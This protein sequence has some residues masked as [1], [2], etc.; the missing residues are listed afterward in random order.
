M[1]KL[2]VAILMLGLMCSPALACQGGNCSDQYIGAFGTVDVSSSASGSGMDMDSTWGAWGVSAAGGHA[3]AGGS[4]VVYDGS[5]GVDVSTIAGGLTDTTAYSGG[6]W[7]PNGW[8]YY[9][10]VG[11][12][13]QAVVGGSV[14]VYV[15]GLGIVGAGFGG[16]AC[17][18]SLDVSSLGS[19]SGIAGQASHA[20]I[21]GLA[22]ALVWGS[23][24]AGGQIDMVGSSGSTSWN[25][26]TF[27][28]PAITYSIGTNV[29]AQTQIN[30]V[31]YD[32]SYGIAWSQVC[33]SYDVIGSA[34]T[35]TTVPGG[36]ASASG[37]YAGHG[38]L[39]TNY[40]G[41][42]SGY[43]YGSITT[44]SGMHGEIVSTGAGMHVTS[45]I[46]L[47]R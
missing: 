20:E 28:G 1:K 26:I 40:T 25:E 8:G 43:S 24:Y 17:Q 10:G 35:T 12:Q 6:Y 29:G 14:S 36:S 2:L 4:G 15:D 27:D 38:V 37:M 46:S 11:S 5:V 18:G 33:G 44:V 7:L 32:S 45:T 47:N 31:G 3:R 39:N 22:G 41:S 13:N 16:Q 19:T 30:A 23:A 9:T 34:S 42:A 21:S